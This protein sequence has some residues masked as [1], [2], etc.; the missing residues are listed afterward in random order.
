MVS[1]EIVKTASVSVWR[2]R[3]QG[4]RFVGIMKK[5]MLVLFCT[6]SVSAADLERVRELKAMRPRIAPQAQDTSKT[7]TVDCTK[8]EKI[9]DAVD[10]NA[11]PLDILVKG[12]CIE[13]VRIDDKDFTLR[14]TDPLVDQIQGTTVAGLT[15]VD[16][17]SAV[18]QNLGFVNGVMAGLSIF[19]SGVSMTNCRV[20][21][22]VNGILVRDDSLFV[23]EGLT[24]SSNF[25]SGIFSDDARF[26]GC[27]GC[28]AENN[29]GFAGRA[30]RGGVLT[31]LDSEIVGAR[32]IIASLGAYAD[33]DCVSE[34][35]GNP[36]SMQAT[37]IAAQAFAG[38]QATLFG[39]GDFTGRVNAF[40]RG[41][42]DLLGARQTALTGGNNVGSFGT[43]LLE[44]LDAVE[45]QLRG[46]T[47]VN[48]FGRALVREQS[49]LDGSISCTSAGD[50]WLDP[51]TIKTPGSTV[52]GCEHASFP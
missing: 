52:T 47:F 1:K 7:V 8:G 25:Q 35:S 37:L 36:C 3:N 12:L 40:D 9:Q 16:V 34:G 19:D 45:S 2:L 31:Y 13:S 10:K 48:N 15:I 50:A 17:N 43:L 30:T 21:G 22:N 42:V 44:P 14:G 46:T 49:T 39:A 24:I 29:G 32:G 26:V 18:V 6:L 27:I 4:L 38:G 33:I 51:T 11:A 23:G 5:L 20:T 41:G 28:R